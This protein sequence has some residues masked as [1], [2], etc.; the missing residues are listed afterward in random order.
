[1]RLSLKQS[2]G[3]TILLTGVAGIVLIIVS[4]GLY[5]DLAYDNERAALAGVLDLK[6]ADRIEVLRQRSQDLGASLQKDPAFRTGLIAR[7]RPA[8]AAL[9]D[10]QHFQYFTT[11]G[12]IKLEKLYVFDAGFEGVASSVHGYD[13]DGGY[14]P[15]CSHLV[16]S[17]RARSGPERLRVRS[18]LCADHGYSFLGV[19]LP[20]GGLNPIG[21]L[22]I[23]TDPAHNLKDMETALASPI[24]VSYANGEIAYRSANW[25]DEASMR[26]Y[27]HADTTLRDEQRQ[28]ILR[29]AAARDLAPFHAKFRKTV[30]LTLAIAILIIAPAMIASALM[31]R[32]AFRPLDKLREASV[33]LSHG[34]FHTIADSSFPEIDVVIGSFNKMA[35]DITRLI[36]ELEGEITQRRAVEEALKQ[37]QGMLESARDQALS[38][39]RAK[40]E[41]LA[42]MSHEIRT[43]LNGII[44]MND[45]VLETELTPSQEKYARAVRHSGEALRAIID[46]IL[47][48]SKIEAGKLELENVDFD[49]RQVAEDV[50]ELF[51]EPAQRKQI[52]ISCLVAADAP[53][54][55][56][57]DPG[58]LR[59]ILSNLIGNAVKFTERGEIAVR[60]TAHELLA[61]GL[62]LRFEVRDT[63]IGISPG[64]Q[65]H[66]FQA[67]TQADGSTT[68]R[69]G[70]TG[71]GL[72]ISRQ[73]AEIMGGHIGV[74]STAGHGSTFWFTASFGFAETN[75]AAVPRADL[76]GL[77]VLIADANATNRDVLHHQLASSGV[78]DDAVAD[79]ASTLERLREAAARGRPYDLV[80]LDMMLPGPDGLAV[81]REIRRDPALAQARL[82][83]LTSI[84]LRG[85]AQAARDSGIEGYLIKPARQR[86]L[87][88]CVARVVGQA[89]AEKTEAAGAAPAEPI[90]RPG[91]R[92]LL[93]EDNDI[94]RDV[95]LSRLAKLGYRADVAPDGHAAVD[96]WAREHYDLV[97]MDCQMPHMDGYEA[98]LEIRR[99][100]QALNR[101]RVAI[102]ALTANALEGDRERCLA[103]GMDDHLAKPFR[104]E[105][106]QEI[107]DRWLSD[108]TSSVAAQNQRLR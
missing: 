80:I 41:F 99:R 85:D 17:A 14:H 63:G 60:V 103:A 47:D 82:V 84:G 18:G 23:V 29:V 91:A 94:N 68:R 95:A 62:I 8:L 101:K 102:V 100:E 40:S 42:N 71:L 7:D 30:Y 75:G 69:F 105:R 5:R 25:P 3:L 55:V 31:L 81:A 26:N 50:C 12:V 74:H 76:A 28:P 59:Q 44:G 19:V 10:S 98:S 48:F 6:I 93:A 67:F 51:S 33:E 2:I 57:G 49:V 43:P 83:M 108:G 106:L 1:M 78:I 92:I 107:L 77:R 104:K 58:R 97:L 89:G 72:T 46:D 4:S 64:A 73:L 34:N 27:L 32:R 65:E 15:L 39:S 90:G 21:Y 70:G 61:S 13:D 16:T 86:D 9:L 36:T 45:L 38:A 79:G 54:R 96:L 88:D 24:H 56:R 37:N 20:V 53:A 11:A 87:L 22:M 52:E 66:I 35:T